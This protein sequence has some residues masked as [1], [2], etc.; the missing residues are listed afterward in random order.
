MNQHATYFDCTLIQTA[1][2]LAVEYQGRTLPGVQVPPGALAGGVGV[3]TWDPGAGAWIFDGYQD[4]SLKRRAE[5]DSPQRMGW[6]NASRPGGWTAP[7]GILPGVQ[8]AFVDDE[9]ETFKVRVPPEFV[10]V[11]AL[12]R[13]PV[14]KLLHA[15]VADACGIAQAPGVPR[16]D[17]YQQTS[18]GAHSAAL[19]Y[20]A[21]AFGEP[22]NQAG[23]VLMP[24]EDDECDVVTIP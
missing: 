2:G 14:S 8:G 24:A 9:T 12:H 1:G 10:T 17:G 18:T 16:A 13:V 11:A 23:R 3:T 15:F 19:G 7:R 5:L 20:L 21:A 6:S 4:P 22:T